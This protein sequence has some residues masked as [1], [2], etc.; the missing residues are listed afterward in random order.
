MALGVRG[1]GNGGRWV[2]APGPAFGFDWPTNR[3]GY[4]EHL[5]VMLHPG[6]ID[7]LTPA[8]PHPLHTHPP[9]PH[10]SG[11]MSCHAEN[12]SLPPSSTLEAYGAPAACLPHSS[13]LHSP[14]PTPCPF[15]SASPLLSSACLLPTS[16]T[17]SPS[18]LCPPFVLTPLPVLVQPAVP[19]KLCPRLHHWDR[20]P[21][22]HER[23]ASRSVYCGEVC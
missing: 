11:A 22:G 5:M 18:S 6:P 23:R 7:S 3:M 12:L 21:V 9:A 17:P 2:G 4:A 15:H 8:L 16:P 10:S 20:K 14:C 13:S 1:T 19:P